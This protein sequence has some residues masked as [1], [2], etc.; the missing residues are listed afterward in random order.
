[1]LCWGREVRVANGTGSGTVADVRPGPVLSRRTALQVAAVGLL[2]SACT[3]SADTDQSPDR[4]TGPNGSTT[5]RTGGSGGD[6][7]SPDAALVLAAVADEEG[8]LS[9]CRAVARRHRS[10]AR[11]AGAVSDRVRAH[12]R[13]LRAVVPDADYARPRRSPRAPRDPAA[14]RAALAERCAAVGDARLD[15]CLA[16]E[17]GLL[18]RLLASTAASHAVTAET[19]LR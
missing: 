17:S 14:A 2:G 15:D 4:R 1:M 3:P 18:A 11:E 16:A 6:A 9:F 10:L 13:R 12:V 5:S 8:L 19:L 7:P